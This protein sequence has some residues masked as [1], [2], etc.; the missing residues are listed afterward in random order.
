MKAPVDANELNT[1][2]VG[3]ASPLSGIGGAMV[4]GG[5]TLSVTPL[6]VTLSMLE[7]PELFSEIQNGPVAL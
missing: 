6:A 5:I 4:T 3:A 2:P 7:T 1:W